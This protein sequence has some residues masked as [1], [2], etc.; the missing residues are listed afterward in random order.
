MAVGAKRW[1]GRPRYRVGYLDYFS[2]VILVIARFLLAAANSQWVSSSTRR[3]LLSRTGMTID[4]S[5]EIHAGVLFGNNTVAVGTNSSINRNCFYDGGAPLTI[6]DECAIAYNVVFCTITH[7][8]GDAHRRAGR[9][10]SR[11][12]KVGNGCW[13]GA[14]A[15][16]LPGVTV[17]DGC[18]IAA[19]AVVRNDCDP[20]SLYAG[21]PARRIG[22][23]DRHS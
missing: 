3:R 11:P 2:K 9:Q 21:V 5:C 15:V 4:P 6:G 19:G 18:I 8:P 13:I 10:I 20:N 22:S 7:E 1:Y 17:G 12:I 16:I 14:N 23:A